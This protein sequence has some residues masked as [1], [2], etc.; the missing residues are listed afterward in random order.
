VPL[1]P[2]KGDEVGIAAASPRV[3]SCRRAPGLQHSADAR[4]ERLSDDDEAATGAPKQAHH[5][6]R[7][8]SEAEDGG[9][10][11]PIPSRR[12]S[13]IDRPA[14]LG[15]R[16]LPLEPG[17]SCGGW[18]V[19]NGSGA[20]IRITRRGGGEGFGRG[21]TSAAELLRHANAT[22]KTGRHASNSDA[23]LRAHEWYAGGMEGLGLF[24]GGTRKVFALQL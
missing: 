2:T 22:C 10:T 17:N 5:A 20:V 18:L 24:I 4:G 11:H 1:S 13:P 3:C 19:R 12:L 6:G 14:R 9:A 8:V 15:T 23:C 16:A 21:G 7:R